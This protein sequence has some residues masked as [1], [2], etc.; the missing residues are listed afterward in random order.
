MTPIGL[1]ANKQLMDTKFDM[2][3]LEGTAQVPDAGGTIYKAAY[4]AYYDI[5]KRQIDEASKADCDD[6]DLAPM[7]ESERIKAENQL[8]EDSHAFAKLFNDAM[9]ECLSEISNQ[10]DAHIKSMMITVAAPA[11]GPGGTALVCA[12]G[13][14]T[15]TIGANNLSP[16]GGIT[17]S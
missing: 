9:K 4:H 15:G 11:P 17:I 8:R 12:T 1:A 3:V 6:V 16:A 13:P 5:A 14:V 2:M 7:F 10:I